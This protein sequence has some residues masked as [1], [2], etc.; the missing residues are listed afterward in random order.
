[1]MTA[2]QW[3]D[4]YTGVPHWDLG[5]PQPAFQDLADSGAITGRVLDAGCG[6]GEHVLMCAARGLDATGVDLAPAAI[7]RAGGKARERGL[8][9]RFLV[10]DARDLTDLLPFDTVLDSGLLHTF[11]DADRAAYLHSVRSVLAPGGR[12]FVLCFSD[13]VR[14]PGGP[15]RL[16]AGELTAAFADG[17]WVDSVAPTTL[18]TSAGG[19]V[20]GWLVRATRPLVAAATVRTDR[21]E[22]YLDQFCRHAR[23]A[24]RIGHR[25]R[26]VSV[27]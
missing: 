4:C 27:H 16:S 15:R 25:A 12:M 17:W 2:S 23:Q 19:G 11:A 18:D 24:H 8:A 5:R 10:R 13:Q 9:A 14:A 22:R 7:A 20:P 21:A 26:Q 1:M 3:N 6:T